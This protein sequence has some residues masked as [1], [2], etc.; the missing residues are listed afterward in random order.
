MA[1]GSESAREEHYHNLTSKQREQI[2]GKN[3]IS[4]GRYPSSVQLYQ[5][6]FI[7]SSC[8]GMKF[9]NWVWRFCIW[10]SMGLTGVNLSF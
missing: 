10:S 1:S 2:L 6:E 4:K 8:P 7:L 3:F 5:N 9:M